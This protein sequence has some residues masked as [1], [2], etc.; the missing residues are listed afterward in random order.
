MIL[1]VD[2]D[3]AYIVEPGYKSRK[4]GLYYSSQ[5]EKFEI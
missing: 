4:E 2:S 5:F 3:A 1:D